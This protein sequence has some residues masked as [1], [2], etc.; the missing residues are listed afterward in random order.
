MVAWTEEEE[1]ALVVAYDNVRANGAGRGR[2]GV[3]TWA[4]VLAEFSQLVGGTRRS[5][6][7]LSHKYSDLL[8]KCQT[9]ENCFQEMV[10]QFPDNDEQTRIQFAHIEYASETGADFPYVSAWQWLRPRLN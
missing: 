6:D 4:T 1:L 2:R 3:I 8:S 5:C 9:F 7:S 10:R